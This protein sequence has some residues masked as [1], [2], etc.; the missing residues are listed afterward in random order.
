M[1]VND[2]VQSSKN[3]GTSASLS[4]CLKPLTAYIVHQC[5]R[6]KLSISFRKRPW[7]CFR[8]EK[9]SLTPQ[10]TWLAELDG[11]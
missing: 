3:D 11:H 8:S 4:C 7:I 5:K 10:K 2:A 6:C 9:I 1:I